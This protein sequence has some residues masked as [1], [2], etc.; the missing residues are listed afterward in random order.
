MTADQHALFLR[1]GKLQELVQLEI[2]SFYLFAKIMLDKVAQ[3]IGQYFGQAEGCSL[4]SHDRFLKSIIQYQKIK[5]LV[6]DERVILIAKNLKKQIA[7]YRDKQISHQ[8]N[9]RTI[10]GT[11]WSATADVRIF[12]TQLY[13]KSTD[14]G[15]IESAPLADLGKE[16]DEYLLCVFSLISNNRP[17]TKFKVKAKV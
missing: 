5:G 15:Q 13:P 1:S 11:A 3:F 17:K 12:T 4:A 2:E 6:L 8:Q 14:P 9:P 10:V 7:D 16:I